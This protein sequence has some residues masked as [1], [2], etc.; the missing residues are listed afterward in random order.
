MIVEYY[1]STINPNC[2][3]VA[4]D[5]VMVAMWWSVRW[6]D[7]G[8]YRPVRS[9]YT[10]VEWLDKPYDLSLI[11]DLDQFEAVKRTGREAHCC[12]PE[13][14]CPVHVFPQDEQ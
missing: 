12:C 11:F 10:K 4:V 2:F 8:V 3:Y 5:N 6:V 13:T 1:E 9:H 7:H 14:L